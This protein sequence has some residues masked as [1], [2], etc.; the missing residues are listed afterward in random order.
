MYLIHEDRIIQNGEMRVENLSLIGADNISKLILD[1]LNFRFGGPDAL[2][3]TLE[4]TSKIGHVYFLL[5]QL[6]LPVRKHE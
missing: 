6:P 4:F 5:R 2:I 3:H 1:L